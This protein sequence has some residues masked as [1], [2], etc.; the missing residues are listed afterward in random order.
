MVMDVNSE[1]GIR[2][3]EFRAVP[4]DRSETGAGWVETQNSK[5]KTQ[6]SAA[7]GYTLVVVVMLVAIMSIMMAVA[8]QTV[9]FQMQREREAELIFRGQQY[10]E[11]IRLYRQKFGRYPMRLKELWEADPKVLRQKWTDPITGS[12]QWGL[13]FLGQEGQQV[14]G[15]GGPIPPGRQRPQATP[16]RTPTFGDRGLGGGGEKIGPIVGVYSLSK[17]TSVKIY[18]G[19][20]QYNEWK[21]VFKEQ[22]GAGGQ[23]G[24]GGQDPGTPWGQV[25][26]FPTPPQPQ[27]TGTPQY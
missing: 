20:T 18:E 23:G 3:S 6:N 22:E 25:T 2:N 21:F 16:T 26:P 9:S 15:A 10:V 4:S 17:D 1:F 7:G 14:G 8:V 24:T 13:V 5:L 12:D 11:G 19:R 27:R